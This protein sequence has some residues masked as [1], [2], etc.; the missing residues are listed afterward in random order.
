[1]HCVDGCAVSSA[2]TC[3]RVWG[4]SA[5]AWSIS[6]SIS[7]IAYLSMM[8]SSAW[9]LVGKQKPTGCST[10]K[11]W[12]GKSLWP[13]D[14]AIVNSCGQLVLCKLCIALHAMELLTLSV[15]GHSIDGTGV[16]LTCRSLSEY[17]RWLATS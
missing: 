11:P 16:G 1:M 7:W 3:G 8:A 12:V 2:G 14:Q 5:F 10:H 9:D 15:A 13:H 6:W 17:V 4:T